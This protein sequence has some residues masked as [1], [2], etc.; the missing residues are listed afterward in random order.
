MPKSMS[1]AAI[2]GVALA[3][4]LSGCVGFEHKSTVVSPSDPAL[5]SYLGEWAAA[6]V[7][8]FPTPQSCGG[9]RWTITSQDANSIAGEFQA[10]CAGGASLTGV[11]SGTID[12]NIHFQASG[13]AAGLGPVTCPFSLTGTGDLQA[14]TTILVTYSGQTRLGPISGT[15]VLRR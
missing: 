4:S 9:L 13:T 8:S 14:N 2:A 7:T 15:E 10:T 6:S 1:V 12:G 5:R 11:A 3:M